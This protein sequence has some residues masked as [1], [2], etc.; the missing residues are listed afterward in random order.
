MFL[1]LFD[2]NPSVKRTFC[3]PKETYDPEKNRDG[4]YG[5]PLPPFAEL[6][7]SGQGRGAQLPGGRESGAC[8]RTIG[9][10]LKQ[11]FQRAMIGRIPEDGA[12][13]GRPLPAGPVLVRRVPVLR[14]RVAR[15][16]RR[17]TRSSSHC[18]ARRNA[19]PSSRP[20]ASARCGP[21]L[22]G[23]PGGRCC[24]LSGRRSSWRCRTIS[25]PGRPPI[26]AAKRSSS[27]ST[28]RSPRAG[29]TRRSACSPGGRS[30]TRAASRASKSYNLQRDFVFEPKIFGELKNAQSIVLAYDGVNPLPPTF[31]Y[32][33][34]YYLDNT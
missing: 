15:A 16:I 24:R 9:T 28:T 26:Y 14:H 7:E 33:K 32:L 25:V 11:D 23:S 6:I 10:L 8:A 34:P 31:C 29:R 27:S 2:D 21:P 5:R 4:K 19:S 3:P 30:R 1:S 20:R 12:E 17:E 13:Q 18:P 22:P